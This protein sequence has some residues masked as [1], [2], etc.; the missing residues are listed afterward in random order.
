MDLNFSLKNK[1]AAKGNSAAGYL[2]FIKRRS[3]NL[4]ITVDMKLCIIDWG[5]VGHIIIPSICIP[6]DRIPALH[7]ISGKSWSYITIGY[8]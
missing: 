3:G 4:L 6:S 5:M 1:E 2:L 7:Q 8:M